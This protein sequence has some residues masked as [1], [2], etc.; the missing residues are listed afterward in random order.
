MSVLVKL[1]SGE[2]VLLKDIIDGSVIVDLRDSSTYDKAHLDGAN[3][4]VM[5]R[6]MLAR[7]KKPMIKIDDY[8][9]CAEKIRA[10]TPETTIILYDQAGADS[11]IIDLFAAKFQEEAPTRLVGKVIGGFE[12]IKDSSEFKLDATVFQPYGLACAPMVPRSPEGPDFNYITENLAVGAESVA[13]NI[14]LLSAEG[15]THVLN[16]SSYECVLN[17]KVTFLWVGMSDSNTQRLFGLVPDCISFIN[18]ALKTPGNKVLIHCHA[19]IS[20]SV[21]IAIIY[22][23]WSER[24]SLNDAVSKVG[25]KRK[26]ASPNLNFLGQMLFLEKALKATNYDINEACKWAERELNQAGE[27]RRAGKQPF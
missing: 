20:R 2:T 19:G 12:A 10:R 3:N 21:S 16:V 14:G 9:M 13:Q 15:F 5:P 7:F 1:T 4:M 8:L 11:T 6:M 17:P 22:Y 26:K 24:L 25:G 18:T 23:M 27:A